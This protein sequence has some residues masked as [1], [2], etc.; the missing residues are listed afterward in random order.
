[1][2]AKTIEPKF[3]PGE[4]V[5]IIHRKTDGSSDPVIVMLKDVFTASGT[6]PVIGDYYGFVYSFDY[7]GEEYQWPEPLL[8]KLESNYTIPG[9]KDCPFVP[10]MIRT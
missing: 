6:S 7:D 8:I 9:W 10:E 5:K 2:D 1:M 3:V 4:Y